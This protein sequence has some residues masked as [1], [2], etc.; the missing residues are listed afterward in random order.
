MDWDACGSAPAWAFH[1]IVGIWR[2]GGMEKS[3]KKGDF[4][5]RFTLPYREYGEEKFWVRQRT[6]A[7]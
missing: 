7:R 2:F 1:S 6:R 5:E 3:G 4:S